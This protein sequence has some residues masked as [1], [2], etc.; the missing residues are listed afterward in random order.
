MSKILDAKYAPADL[1]KVANTNAH[2]THNQKEKLYALLSKHEALFDGTLGKWEGGPY[3]AELCEEE[4]PCHARPY[5]I[6][7]AYKR[8]LQLEVDRL[9]EVGVLQINK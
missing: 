5:S 1:R 9:C 4:K 8:T 7:H 3:H 2:L 6:P